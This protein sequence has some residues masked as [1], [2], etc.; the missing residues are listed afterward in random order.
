MNRQFVD[1]NGLNAVHGGVTGGVVEVRR[2]RGWVGEVGVATVSWGGS[3]TGSVV[4]TASWVGQRL[5]HG[6][7]R[8]PRFGVGEGG[9]DQGVR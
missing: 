4:A 1:H 3:A 5:G 9:G 6:G 7:G 8:F 2:G